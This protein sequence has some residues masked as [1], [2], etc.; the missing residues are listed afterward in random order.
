[1]RRAFHK[2]FPGNPGVWIAEGIFQHDDK[3]LFFSQPYITAN[4]VKFKMPRDGVY[5]YP[6]KLDRLK[7]P[8]ST[9]CEFSSARNP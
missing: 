3:R 8:V 7:V 2:R 6:D 4:G 5:H 9:L 1:M